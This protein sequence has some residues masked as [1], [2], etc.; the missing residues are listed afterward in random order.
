MF[1]C[2]RGVDTYSKE[3]FWSN[4]MID[5][6]LVALSALVWYAQPLCVDLNYENKASFYFT[7]SNRTKTEW[8]RIALPAKILP[9]AT[10]IP[11]SK[12]PKNSTTIQM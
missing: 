10:V 8:T 1:S 9:A 2:A 6:L 5:C 7:S 12:G 4:I 11:P 3:R